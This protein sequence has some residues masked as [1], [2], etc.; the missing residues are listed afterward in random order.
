MLTW[1]GSILGIL[2]VG[3]L[4]L[5]WYVSWSIERDLQE[6]AIELSQLSVGLSDL[7]SGLDSISTAFSDTAVVVEFDSLRVD[8]ID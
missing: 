3:Y 2:A 8:T 6:L 7:S 4:A 5:A 1:I